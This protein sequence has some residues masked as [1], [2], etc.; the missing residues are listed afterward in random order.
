MTCAACSARVENGL[1]RIKWVSSVSVNFLTGRT[2][3][4]IDHGIFEQ[5]NSAP[6]VQNYERASIDTINAHVNLNDNSVK[7]VDTLCS[8]VR[9]IGYGAE[10]MA[11]DTKG[12]NASFLVDGMVCDEC[13]L[14]IERRLLSM[15]GVNTVVVD[16]DEG[17]V[18]VVGPI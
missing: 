14:R 10:T 12:G 1:K 2:N 7:M 6:S 3:V 16:K 18:A 5:D 4:I 13:P 9:S 8:A 15:T 11:D 17:R